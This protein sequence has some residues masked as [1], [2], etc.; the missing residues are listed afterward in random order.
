MRSLTVVCSVPMGVC[1][2]EGMIKNFN[3][4]EEFKK[5]DRPA[6]LKKS[7]TMVWICLPLRCGGV[8]D[9]GDRSGRRYS[10]VLSTSAHRSSRRFSS[11][12]MRI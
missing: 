8:A 9:Y 3:T 4:I 2:A 5:A 6:M 1:R 7:A 12:R 10:T 11:Y